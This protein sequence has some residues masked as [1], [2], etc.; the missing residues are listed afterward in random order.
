VKAL[1]VL[2]CGGLLLVGCGVARNTAVTSYHVATAPVT[3]VRRQFSDQPPQTAATSSDVDVPGRPVA[4]PSPTPPRRTVAETSAP[5]RMNRSQPSASPR[6]A[7]NQ[8]EF[9]V[10]KPVPG[11]SGYVY[12]PYDSSKYVDVSGYTPGSKVKDPYTQKIFIVP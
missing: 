1:G 11:K 3:I 12:S 7:T 4:V 8:S 9:P 2:F 6:A 5:Q 10:A